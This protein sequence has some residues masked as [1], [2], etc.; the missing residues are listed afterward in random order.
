MNKYKEA[1]AELSLLSKC[2]LNGIKTKNINLA[3]EVLREKLERETIKPL[4]IEQLLERKGEPVYFVRGGQG[5]W[6][7][8]IDVEKD[9]AYFN[10]MEIK[11]FSNYGILWQ[12]YDDEVEVEVNE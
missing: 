7:I 1:I 9:K 12:C 3:I 11:Y 6:R 8:L 4:T 10:S 5:S 2:N